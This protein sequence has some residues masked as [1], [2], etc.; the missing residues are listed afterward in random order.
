MPDEIRW[1]LGVIGSIAA[2]FLMVWWRVESR[3]D[4]KID[5]MKRD[6]GNEHETLHRKVDKVRDKVE[7][8]WK[9][10]VKDRSI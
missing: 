1:I 6:N 5:E 3:Q 7:E 4:Q 9:H 2:V 10:L 8:I